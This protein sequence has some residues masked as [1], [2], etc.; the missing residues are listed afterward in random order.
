MDMT[1][2]ALIEAAVVTA[3]LS[4]ARIFIGGKEGYSLYCLIGGIAVSQA[5]LLQAKIGKYEDKISVKL[6]N[7]KILI[8]LIGALTYELAIDGGLSRSDLSTAGAIRAAI[9]A[10]VALAA[11]MVSGEISKLLVKNNATA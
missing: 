10:G 7:S 9:G 2:G 6:D 8:G 3:A 1:M 5:A 11:S 4:G